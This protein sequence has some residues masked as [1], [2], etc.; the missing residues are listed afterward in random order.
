[1]LE[2]AVKSKLISLRYEIEQISV[3]SDISIAIRLLDA[4]EQEIGQRRAEDEFL[5]LLMTIQ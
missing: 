1:M 3:F 2:N 5:L 4:I